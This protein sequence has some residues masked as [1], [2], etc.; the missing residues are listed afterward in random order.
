MC[1][2]SGLLLLISFWVSAYSYTVVTGIVGEGVILPCTVEYKDKFSYNTLNIIWRTEGVRVHHFYYGNVQEKHQDKMFKGRTQLFYAEFPKGNLSLLLNNIRISDAG[3]YECIVF[4]SKYTFRIKT[5]LVVQDKAL[6][7]T[8]ES[9]GAN[10]S[11]LVLI[12]CV[13][14]AFVVFLRRRKR[15]RGSPEM[16]SRRNSQDTTKDERKPTKEKES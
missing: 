15:S 9:S 14:I 13:V 3:I 4:I 7:F 5:E 12:I 11:I 6:G 1:M 2:I 8:N 10:F 16:Q